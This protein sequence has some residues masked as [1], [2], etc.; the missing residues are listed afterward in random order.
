[1]SQVVPRSSSV[2]VGGSS[3]AVV[4]TPLSVGAAL[5]SELADA[6]VGRSVARASNHRSAL[7][8]AR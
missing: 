4:G 6:Q 3:A 1:M 2:E 7:L 5:L 8:S